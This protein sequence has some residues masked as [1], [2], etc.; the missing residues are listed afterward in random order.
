MTKTFGE[1]R[2]LLQ[3]TPSREVFD[4]IGALYPSGELPPEEMA[5][6][7]EH[8]AQ[9]PD[10]IQRS[11]PRAWYPAVGGVWPEGCLLCTRL[12]CGGWDFGLDGEEQSVLYHMISGSPN[13]SALTRLEV[14]AWVGSR[15]VGAKVFGATETLGSL[16]S[17]RI[18]R[19]NLGSRHMPTMLKLERTS[20]LEWFEFAQDSLEP[21]DY[22]LFAQHMPQLRHLGLE[23]ITT[24]SSGLAHIL[25]FEH[26]ESLHWQL[27]LFDSGDPE[28]LGRHEAWKLREFVLKRCSLSLRGLEAL[29]RGTLLGDLEVLSLEGAG[30]GSGVVGVL[31]DGLATEGLR[32]LDLSM[33]NLAAEGARALSQLPALTGVESLYLARNGLGGSEQLELPEALDEVR[34]LHLESNWIED[35]AFAAWWERAQLP[36]L[37][38]LYLWEN[39]IGPKSVT[40]IARLAP[41]SLRAL[42]L[43][44]NP[45]GDEGAL[46]LA[47][48]EALGSLETLN[49]SGCKIGVEA[50]RAILESLHLP[51]LS[52]L[53]LP[54]FSREER[55]WFEDQ[56]AERGVRLR[57]G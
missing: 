42:V 4:A 53:L 43:T 21:Q 6:A 39:F 13:L 48:S 33:N 25:E 2:S 12:R 30:L 17:L 20:E 14:M 37:D 45:V 52:S 27:M 10:G 51:S 15:G 46:A 55:A 26:L 40:A 54:S 24:R 50:S 35:E 18:E 16:H 31:A 41:P 32:T 56:A 49:L 9:W 22:A 36:N 8:F 19:A 11:V 7:Q 5:Y 34:A 44:G 3:K 23:A 38:V 1:L 29:C 47:N 57:F 28:L